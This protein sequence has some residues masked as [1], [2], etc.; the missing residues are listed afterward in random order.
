MFQ[1]DKK[2]QV[3]TNMLDIKKNNS[4]SVS[5]S[6][7][8]SNSRPKRNDAFKSRQS[9]FIKQKERMTVLVGAAKNKKYN[10]RY[11]AELSEYIHMCDASSL[12]VEI[13][14][15]VLATVRAS[16]WHQFHEG[17]ITEEVTRLLV[18]SVEVAM[19][20]GSLEAQW[21]HVS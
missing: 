9:V 12:M 16:Y 19:D 18:E 13:R 10:D 14:Q 6:A 20:K 8:A 21:N 5:A 4:I 15:R 1:K 17:M 2:R 3:T 11:T 7:S